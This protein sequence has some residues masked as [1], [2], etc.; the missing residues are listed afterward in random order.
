MSDAISVCGGTAPVTTTCRP[1]SA[2]A[3]RTD[4][5]RPSID[6]AILALAI[7]LLIATLTQMRRALQPVMPLMRAALAA[8]FAV[9]FV[10]IALALLL[11]SVAV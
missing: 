5:P 3:T 10:F 9:A 2:G 8:I 4:E 7:V 11:A 1:V 6:T